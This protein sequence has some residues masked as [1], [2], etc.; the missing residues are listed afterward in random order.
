MVSIHSGIPS[1]QKGLRG[2]LGTKLRF[3][4]VLKKNVM[5]RHEVLGEAVS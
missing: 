5:L 1:P 3:I 4:V 2:K